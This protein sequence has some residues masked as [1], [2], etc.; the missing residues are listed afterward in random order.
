[1][2]SENEVEIEGSESWYEMARPGMDLVNE[3]LE[4]RARLHLYHQ[5]C[6]SQ[7]QSIQVGASR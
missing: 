7:L 4:E 3:W 2:C 1:M 6:R 5:S